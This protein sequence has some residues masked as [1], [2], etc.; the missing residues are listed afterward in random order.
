[1]LEREARRSG[2]DGDGDG[3][4]V[5]QAPSPPRAPGPPGGSR[6]SRGHVAARR[7]VA[8]ILLVAVA[9]VA[10]FVISLF[11]PGKGGGSGS[12]PVTIPSGS[13]VS[14]IGDI[15]HSRGV[16][17]SSFFFEL[18]ARMAGKS[19]D[20]KPGAYT[21][22]H[23]MSYGSAL[24]ALTKGVA[25]NVVHITLPEGQDRSQIAPVVRQAGLKGSYLAASIK[26]PDLNPRLYGAKHARNLEGFL[27]PASY[28]LKKGDS[29]GDLVSKQLDAFKQNFATV[30]MSYARKKNL[31]KYDVLTIASM[32]EREAQV[33]GDRALVASVIYNRLHLGMD[34]QIDATLRFAL[35]DWDKPLTQ[36]QL[37][38][39]HG[40]QHAQPPRAA[41]GSD[42]QPGH[43]LDPGRRASGP[44]GL[45]L[46]RGEA[47][48]MRQA[49]LRHDQRAVRAGRGALQRSAGQESRQRAHQ[50]LAGPQLAGVLGFPVAH[51]R[52][53]DIQNA[54]FR[55]LGLDWRYVKLPVPPE[56]FAETVRALPGSGYRGA[57]VTIPHKRAALA[58]ADERTPAAVAIGAA[59]TLSFE[60]GAIEADNTDAPGFLAALDADPAGMRALVLGAGGAGRAVAWA[61]REA[62]AAEVGVW[63]RTPERAAELAAELDVRHV[64]RPGPCDLLVNAT[65]VGLEPPLEGEEA[66]AALG[67]ESLEP[68]P[69]VVD[70]VYSARR[71][72]LLEWA[73]AGG[74]DHGGRPG[75]A[76]AAGSAQFP[77]LDGPRGAARRHARGGRVR[78]MTRLL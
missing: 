29:A 54:A 38:L 65:S 1:M 37:D 46:L 18:R 60:R 40:L 32:V 49:R 16:V 72:A 20:L 9:A 78:S 61:L 14:Q 11:Q 41:A 15:L 62:G 24:D 33:P 30:D 22:K 2:R 48:H 31:S 53:P 64:E 4:Y 68:P 43:G 6:P 76:G 35:H 25:P 59:N 7:F 26:S 27:F 44:H 8:L 21:L 3:H 12:V 23:G 77:A 69:V 55:S 28:E 67:L 51:S 45:P 5:A 17:S 36:S 71:S 74:I 58:L 10:W 13:S 75:G 19:G 52:S 70:L 42:R 63:N 34:L 47:E 66:L 57:N 39:A 50:V 73:A 56:L